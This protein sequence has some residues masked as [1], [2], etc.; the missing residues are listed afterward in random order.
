MVKTAIS[1]PS[2][3]VRPVVPKF[4]D[5]SP[6]I[7]SVALVVVDR[8]PVKCWPNDICAVL[9]ATSSDAMSRGKVLNWARILN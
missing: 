1:S 9:K 4:E 8:Q 2:D 6:G 5:T 7:R 3:S